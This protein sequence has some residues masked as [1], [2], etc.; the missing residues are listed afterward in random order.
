[1]IG[2]TYKMKGGYLL[3]GM[4][5]LVCMCVVLGIR[6]DESG[7]IQFP[8]FSQ[9]KTFYPGF[10]HFGGNYRN[11][12]IVSLLGIGDSAHL[13]LHDTTAL[14][15]SYVLNKIGNQHSIGHDVI[16]LSQYGTDSVPDKNGVQYIFHPLAFGP[17]LADK[18]GYP[19]VTKMHLFDPVKTKE[20][21]RNKQGIMRVITYTQKDNEPKG[22]IALWDC[23]GFYKARDFFY[24]HTLL[25]VEFW[26]ATD[27]DC[28][29]SSLPSDES[30]NKKT[31]ISDNI[32]SQELSAVKDNRAQPVTAEKTRT[33]DM[34]NLLNEIRRRPSNRDHHKVRG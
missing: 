9:M 17:F 12:D 15:L 19:S 1:M 25:S 4:R 31:P 24:G 8:P 20:A 23:S 2:L 26:E 22:H 5:M 16:R 14:R 21:F 10:K 3:Q 29:S 18:Y 34:L 33:S 32:D 28:S 30:T 27:S 11:H 7:K 13:L 6:G